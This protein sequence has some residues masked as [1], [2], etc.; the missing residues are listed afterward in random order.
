MPPGNWEVIHQW[1]PGFW[2]GVAVAALGYSVVLL[3][4][5]WRRRAHNR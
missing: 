1:W 5:L 4:I 3:V 2:C